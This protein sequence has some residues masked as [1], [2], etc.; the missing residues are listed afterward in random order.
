MSLVD[1]LGS[2]EKARHDSTTATRK[3]CL[4]EESVIHTV[5]GK[6]KKEERAVPTLVLETRFLR[7]STWNLH[8]RST[9]HV[10]QY[11]TQRTV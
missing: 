8:S 9:L 5:P 10:L 3:K 7:E 2:K 6:T 1:R 11:C 4:D